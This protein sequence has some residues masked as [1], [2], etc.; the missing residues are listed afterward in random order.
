MKQNNFLTL[1]YSL[2]DKV[3]EFG[4]FGCDEL[5]LHFPLSNL[6]SFVLCCATRDNKDIIGIKNKYST[7]L[8]N[9]DEIKLK[10]LENYD[11]LED[12]KLFDEYN[13]ELYFDI[14]IYD[15]INGTCKINKEKTI[16]TTS[17]CSYKILL[18]DTKIKQIYIN[19]IG[20]MFNSET[21]KQLF[22]EFLLY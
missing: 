11:V 10:K 2:K 1:F 9:T 20:Y 3:Q 21:R 5:N 12:I 16:F 22:N 7:I 8:Q 13:N 19:A 4:Y 17:T 18:K 6:N 14:I 15:D